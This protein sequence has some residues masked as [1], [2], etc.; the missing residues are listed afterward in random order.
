VE[1]FTFALSVNQVPASHVFFFEQ[2]LF[3]EVKEGIQHF[4]KP[5]KQVEDFM[6][7]K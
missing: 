1:G 7:E 3:F 6:I 4:R 5:N 2:S